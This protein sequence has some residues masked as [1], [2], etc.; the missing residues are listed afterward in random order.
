M[1]QRGDGSTV[2]VTYVDG[3]IATGQR[4]WW[5]KRL[6]VPRGRNQMQ[7]APTYDVLKPW[8]GIS[9]HISVN[10]NG[11][12]LPVNGGPEFLGNIIEFKNF[13]TNIFLGDS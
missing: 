13:H 4:N 9:L 11:L 12:G 7:T 8:C 3:A 10:E 6:A 2:V 1:I 5:C